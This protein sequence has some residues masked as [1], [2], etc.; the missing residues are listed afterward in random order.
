VA[1]AGQGR[2][3]PPS[4]PP[5]RRGAGLTAGP[6]WLIRPLR[7]SDLPLFK[8]LRLEALRQHPEAFASSVEDE[9]DSDLSYMIGDRPN[10]TLG[11][12]VGSALVGT[13]ALVVSP[14]LKQRHKGHI[15]GVYVAPLWRRTGLARALTLRLIAEA[16]ANRLT[17][18]TL[19]V[20]TGNDAA[21][22][23]Y[24]NAGFVPY[25][26]EPGSLMIGDKL[27]DTELMALFL[28]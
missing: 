10:V 7:P 18:L 2:R 1:A 27:L 17:V 28:D 16:G 15:A 13:A 9:R 3:R 23:L 22:Q 19:S 4:G 21:R 20:T 8:P 25:A 14:K 11:G 6:P 5:H 12:F 26:T 24:L